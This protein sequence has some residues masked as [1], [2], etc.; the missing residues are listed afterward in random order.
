[1]FIIGTGS[2]WAFG[3]PTYRKSGRFADS[4][5][6]RATASETPR[7]ALAPSLDLLGVPS[8]S[9]MRWSTSRCSDA[10]KPTSSGPIPSRTAFTALSTPLPPYRLPPS[11]S[12]IASN[13][14]VDAPDG[15]AARLTVPSSSATSTSMVGFPRESRISRAPTASMDA[16]V[17]S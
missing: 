9:S 14:P 16:K 3:P 12:S 15:T 8:S 11:R 4:A 2:R 13:A 17:G 10:S 5:A 7:M 6:A 1:M